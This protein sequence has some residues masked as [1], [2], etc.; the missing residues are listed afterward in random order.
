M[1]PGIYLDQKIGELDLWNQTV[2]TLGKR[3]CCL[4]HRFFQLPD[5]EDTVCERYLR[6][7]PSGKLLVDRGQS[8]MK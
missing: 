6:Q 5:M 4:W 8:L 2:G 1:R 3:E 7:S